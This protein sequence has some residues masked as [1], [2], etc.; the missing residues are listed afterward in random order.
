MRLL[1]G[2]EQ[3]HNVSSKSTNRIV[4]AENYHPENNFEKCDSLISH[5]PITK[6]FHTCSM[7]LLTVIEQAHNVS[8]KSLKRIFRCGEYHSENNYILLKNQED[9]DFSR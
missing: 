2:I 6:R 5:L 8:P 1:T 3:S 4:A 9:L 7:R